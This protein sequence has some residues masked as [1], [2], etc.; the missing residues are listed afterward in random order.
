V[1]RI[2]RHYL[3]VVVVWALTLAG[4]YFLQQYFS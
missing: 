2:R 4:L 3:R 1:S